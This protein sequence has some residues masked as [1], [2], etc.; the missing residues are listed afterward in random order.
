VTLILLGTLL[1]DRRHFLLGERSL[2]FD[3]LDL[4]LLLTFLASLPP[5]LFAGDADREGEAFCLRGFLA[6]SRDLLRRRPRERLREAAAIYG[7]N[8]GA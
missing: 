7:S 2:R 1:R 5:F 4:D 8:C 6:F 3:E